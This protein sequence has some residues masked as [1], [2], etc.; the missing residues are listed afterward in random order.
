MSRLVIR[1]EGWEHG[2]GVQPLMS[3]PFSVFHSGL[4]TSL[5]LGQLS[6]KTG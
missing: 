6:C 3:H 4:L 2:S 5:H 1:A